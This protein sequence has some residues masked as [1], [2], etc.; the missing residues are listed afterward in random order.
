M[1]RFPA[2]GPRCTRGV[3]SD[4]PGP[5]GPPRPALLRVRR[6]GRG[7]RALAL[8]VFVVRS[9]CARAPAGPGRWGPVRAATSQGGRPGASLFPAPLVWVQGRAGL[10]ALAKCQNWEEEEGGGV[11][12]SPCDHPHPVCA[13][14]P[15]PLPAK[16]PS[17]SQRCQSHPNQY[18]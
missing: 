11:R 8:W 2:S 6:P 1:V 5:P 13:V 16:I 17:Q 9:G 12:G 14:A 18:D 3:T 10:A 4:T 7:A 15:Q